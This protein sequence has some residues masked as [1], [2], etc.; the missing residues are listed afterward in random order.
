MA[1]S[2]ESLVWETKRNKLSLIGP[3]SEEA[4]IFVWEKVA[5]FV[6]TLM[7]QKKV[8]YTHRALLFFG[9]F[10]WFYIYRLWFGFSLSFMHRQLVSETL[11]RSLLPKG[12][13]KWV[14]IELFSY[15]DLCL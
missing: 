13:L 11:E 2:L 6:E 5:W 9:F 10:F 8:L 1:A 3:L 4:V 12:K 14:T 7:L 15:R